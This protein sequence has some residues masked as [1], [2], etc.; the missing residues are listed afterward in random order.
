M[1]DAQT[2]LPQE[3]APA[4]PETEPALPFRSDTML[5]VCEA[6][7]QDFGFNANYLR[8]VLA[9]MVLWNPLATVGIYLGL[10]IAVA[11][12]RWIYPAPPQAAAPRIEA[13]A[14]TPMADN[15]ADEE[16]LAA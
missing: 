1:Q 12:S 15:Q 2:A 3:A 11:L 8:V 4:A 13:P 10:G 6:L 5:G 9:A 14:A 7:G 16:R